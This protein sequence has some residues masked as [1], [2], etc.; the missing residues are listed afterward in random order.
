MTA[1]L[2]VLIT[3]LWAAVLHAEPA[4]ASDVSAVSINAFLAPDRTLY[5]EVLA[6]EYAGKPMPDGQYVIIG[7]YLQRDGEANQVTFREFDEKGFVRTSMGEVEGARYVS[8]ELGDN[9]Y[10]KD[11]KREGR[12]ELVNGMMTA[13]ERAKLLGK[14]KELEPY[15]ARI[16]VTSSASYYIDDKKRLWAFGELSPA[17]HGSVPGTREAL[18]VRTPK[19]ISAIPGA[20]QVVADSYEGAALT[21]DG[22]IW[23]WN[24]HEE[25]TSPLRIAKIPGA[26]QI[27]ISS[28]GGL[29]LKQDGT[30]Y[31]WDKPE[32][33]NGQQAAKQVKLTKL[34]QLQKVEKIRIGNAGQHMALT[35]DG[36]VW[37]WTKTIYEKDSVPEQLKGLPIIVDLEPYCRGAFLISEQFDLWM[38]NDDLASPTVPKIVNT[39]SHV[40]GIFKNLPEVKLADGG[41]SY[42]SQYAVN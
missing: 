13:D 29:V 19:L 14:M 12:F 36:T 26:K 31:A 4:S 7:A 17:L 42:Y 25:R 23:Y 35:S 5:V 22:Q 8:V 10:W 39:D 32:A 33:M 41:F 6:P 37:L 27:Q 11:I 28:A 24:T 1:V 16:A 15:K 18:Y 9:T 3:L 30:V 20:V 38:L 21:E 34:P 40:I 2:I